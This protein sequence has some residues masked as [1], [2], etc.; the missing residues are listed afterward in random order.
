M[1]EHSD[2]SVSQA[3]DLLAGEAGHAT[4]KVDVRGVVLRGDEVLL[5]K[6]KDDGLW[7]LP[8]GWAEV[9]KTPKESVAR[10]VLEESGFLVEVLRLL[11]VHDRNQHDLTPYPFAVYTLFFLCRLTGEKPLDNPETSE[12]A[13]FPRTQMPEL[14]AYR[15]SPEQL[16]RVFRICDDQTLQ[17]ELD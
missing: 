3:V 8:G 10:E 5:V 15:V 4:P 1:A 2:V 7:S 14:S 9:G 16:K 11:A 12:A 6:E 13:F 17:A